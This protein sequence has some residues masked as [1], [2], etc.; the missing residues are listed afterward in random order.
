M[1]LKKLIKILKLKVLKEII[2]KEYFV[3]DLL[4]P[5]NYKKQYTTLKT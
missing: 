1:W 2:F 3:D 4:V 5:E